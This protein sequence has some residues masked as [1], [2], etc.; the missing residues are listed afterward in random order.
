MN[1]YFSQ[2]PNNTFRKVVDGVIINASA[3]DIQ[4]MTEV[5]L[6]TEA[7]APV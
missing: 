2:I 1:V 3:Q 7:P 5:N 4:A 6:N